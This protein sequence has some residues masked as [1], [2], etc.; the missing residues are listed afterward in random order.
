MF[1]K[2]INADEILQ[3]TYYGTDGIPKP[4]V[5]EKSSFFSKL[6]CSKKSKLKKGNCF[7]NLF[8][9]AKFKRKKGIDGF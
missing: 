3:E 1:K 6:F 7:K 5:E 4:E 2:K 9:S 8:S